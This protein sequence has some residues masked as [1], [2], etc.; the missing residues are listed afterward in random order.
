MPVCAAISRGGLC[1][2]MQL[3]VCTGHIQKHV[4]DLCK[5]SVRGLW[6]HLDMFLGDAALKIWT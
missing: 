3:G 1:Y 5:H 6:L 2:E 4:K